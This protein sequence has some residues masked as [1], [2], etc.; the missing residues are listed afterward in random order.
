MVAARSTETEAEGGPMMRRRSVLMVVLAIVVGVLPLGGAAA[1]AAPLRPQGAPGTGAIGGTVFDT[2]GLGVGGIGVDVFT[3]PGFDLVGSTVSNPDGSW[4]IDGLTPG[5]I[6]A[7]VTWPDAHAEWLP[8]VT[9][10][11]FATIF[12][13]EADA[14]VSGVDF[15][16]VIGGSVSGYVT[17]DGAPATGT[18][19]IV[20]DGLRSYVVP[21]QADGSYSVTHIRASTYQVFAASGNRVFGVYGGHVLSDAPN[22]SIADGQALTGIDIAVSLAGSISGSVTSPNGPVDGATVQVVDSTTGQ[23]V[24]STTTNASGT[25]TTEYVAHGSYRVAASING[26]TSW[27]GGGDSFATA[28]TITHGA[29]P[30]DTTDIGVYLP[31]TEPPQYGA[32][33]GR[34]TRDGVAATNAYVQLWDLNG[35]YGGSTGIDMDGYYV[36]GGLPV[37]NTYRVMAASE[38]TSAYYGG[39][40]LETATPVTVVAGTTSGID[41]ALPPNV[42][43]SGTVTRGG[44]PI[45]GASVTVYSSMFMWV[46][47]TTT[48]ADGSYSVSVA[49]GSYKVQ[50][51]FETTTRYIGGALDFWQAS[52]I[53]VNAPGDPTASGNDIDLPVLGSISGILTRN[54]QPVTDATQVFAAPTNGMGMW[55]YASVAPDGS[56]TISGLDL[57]SYR[58]G[59]FLPGATTAYYV[60]GGTATRDQMM[61]S[62]V[63]VDQMS[64]TVSGV[65]FALPIVGEISGRV[66]SG[67]V[68]VPN[69]YVNAVQANCTYA[70]TY[71]SAQ[72]DADGRFVMRNVPEG[73]YIVYT[74]A[75]AAM[76]YFHGGTSAATA[77]VVQISSATLAAGNI[78]ITLPPGRIE[79]TLTYRGQPVPFVSVS[80]QPVSGMGG[81]ATTDANGHFSIYALN[82]GDYA[83]FASGS[84]YGTVVYGGGST[85]NPTTRISITAVDPV[86]SG[87]EIA[88]GPGE[89]SGT[90][91]RNGQ[92][93]S[94][95][96]VIATPGGNIPGSTATTDMNGNFLVRGIEGSSVKLAVRPDLMAMGSQPLWYGGTSEA[97]ATSITLAGDPPAA[98][99]IVFEVPTGRIDLTVTDGGTPYTQGFAVLVRADAIGQEVQ[100]D[101]N[102]FDGF[103]FTDLAPGDYKVRFHTASNL[104]GCGCTW[105]GGSSFDTA[106]VITVGAGSVPASIELGRGTISG[107]VVTVGGPPANG[108]QVMLYSGPETLPYSMVY[109]A[110]LGANQTTF[111]MTGVPAGTYSLKF[112]GQGWPFPSYWAG[113][114]TWANADR[115][116]LTPGGTLSNI[117]IAPPTGSI[118]GRVTNAAGQPMAGVSVQAYTSPATAIS[119][120]TTDADGRYT[121]S[122]LAPDTY[123][124]LFSPP[125]GVNSVPEWSGGVIAYGDT[126]A[127]ATTFVL[128]D[129]QALTGIDAQLDDGA[130]ISGCVTDTSGAPVPNV[131]VNAGT[132][133]PEGYLQYIGNGAATGS[134]GCYHLTGLGSGD[135]QLGFSVDPVQMLPEFR[136]LLTEYWD[137][138]Y[139]WNEATLFPLALGQHATGKNAVLEQGAQGT[140]T[141]TVGGSPLPL[142]AAGTTFCK[143][144]GVF[145]SAFTCSDGSGPIWTSGAVGP[146]SPGTWNVRAARGGYMTPLELGPVGQLTVGVA[147]VFTCVAPMETA[148]TCS[149]LVDDDGVPAAVEASAPNS[150]D[151]N[152]DGIPDGQQDEVA[153]V[154]DPTGGYVTVESV[155]DLT[156]AD[157]SV[158]DPA[159]VPAPPANVDPQSGL[160]AFTV[161]DLP[162]TLT[163]VQIKVFLPVPADSYWKYDPVNGWVDASSLVTFSPDGL[164]ATITLTDGAF[165]DQDGVVN[166]AIV[167][168]G[169]FALTDRTQVP[170]S[171]TLGGGSLDEGSSLVLQ[172]TVSGAVGAVTTSWDLGADGS[173]NGTAATFTISGADGPSS[174]TVQVTVGDADGRTASA[175]ATYSVVN[176]APAA[177]SLSAPTRVNPHKKFDVSV[178]GLADVP[179]DRV[180]VA[181]DCGSGVFGPVSSPRHGAASVECK[182]PKATGSVVVRVRVT[183]DDGGVTVRSATVQVRVPTKPGAPTALVGTAGS[184]RV[185]LSWTAPTDDGGAPLLGYVV[186]ISSNG[187]RSW[188]DVEARGERDRGC[189][190]DVTTTLTSLTVT[191]LRTNTT[192]TFRVRAVNDVGAS[193]PSGT[194][195]VKAR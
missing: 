87:I 18:Q 106:Q 4:S 159:T 83:V 107:T 85:F 126:S 113:G 104:Y 16:D 50:V 171:V 97:T 145:T 76:Q 140:S 153:S 102:G 56:W 195:T 123:F 177:S 71:A 36:F 125:N 37:G 110:Y 139:V 120:V 122:N 22:T 178:S 28:A 72:T 131:Y 114:S 144:P 135:I 138:A 86:E 94:G 161:P 167:D 89:V 190:D 46:A 150:G 116:T 49:P 8:G 43:L 192:Y 75:G 158:V 127:Q 176:V 141:V 100:Q 109:I 184:K 112:I 137:G 26:N 134:D 154:P 165:G 133:S 166:G 54:G 40:T 11:A 169:V 99:G 41:V 180:Q 80:A 63:T 92:P 62:P 188:D 48:A 32:I 194:V 142:G 189:S 33:S 186:E 185:V 66:M 172:P 9:D 24:V 64:P 19:V 90:V 129:D 160:V 157:V 191:G 14:A 15:H 20:R 10:P 51:Q 143:A 39:S 78:D 70:C 29:S 151:G 105:V 82:P 117:V 57:G 119:P 111:T 31:S 155:D 13:V 65:Q 6:I 148:P 73:G 77:T 156:L 68:G 121:V 60:A 12:A 81:S 93:V 34:I 103:S 55:Q 174:I 108:G 2:A 132:L 27:H 170:L 173:V 149:V 181:W 21:V 91:L 136:Y 95:A 164:V 42:T 35:G 124:M 7:R 183:D 1:F 79:G 61:A 84:V 69:A 179:G 59:V 130:Q 74:L 147:D 175:T 5:G 162:P 163:T 58:I 152:D 146:L 101:S 168:P 115:Y 47:N 118:S 23:L 193:I 38:G 3:S 30:M 128:G 17:R 44:Q 45:E 25:F 53:T 98:S 187:G 88:F 96:L 52:T 182:A 67:T